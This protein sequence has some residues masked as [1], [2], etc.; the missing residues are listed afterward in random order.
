VLSLYPFVPFFPLFS[1]LLLFLLPLSFNKLTPL[2]FCV[3]DAKI[4]KVSSVNHQ[5]SNRRLPFMPIFYHFLL[6]PLISCTNSAP[7]PF[8]DH[9][10][11]YPIPF[12]V[13]TCV[14]VLID[15]SQVFLQIP[16]GNPGYSGNATF[17]FLCFFADYFDF[18]RLASLTCRFISLNYLR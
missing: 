5:N 4:R 15:Y 13:K 11:P 14:F 6:F 3:L 17:I 16:S 7:L 8:P 12:S 1:I 2:T 10:I 18:S 9:A